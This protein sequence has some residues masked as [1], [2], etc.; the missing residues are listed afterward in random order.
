MSIAPS[1][2]S[3]PDPFPPR[4]F[5]ERMLARIHAGDESAVQELVAAM[6]VFVR[7]EAHALLRGPCR[8]REQTEDVAQDVLMSLLLRFPAIRD[9]D[10][11]MATTRRMIS[12]QVY[13]VYTRN[14]RECR[15]VRRESSVPDLDT[16]AGVA[17]LGNELT[18]PPQA[19]A[20]SESIDFLRIVLDL[21]RPKDRQVFDAFMAGQSVAEMAA[22][23][24]EKPDAVRMRLKR[25]TQEMKRA[26]RRRAPGQDPP[27]LGPV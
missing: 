8:V 25:A 14:M 19:A 27:S 17:A 9:H 10:H 26:W 24:G 12:N 22:A 13:D 15:D 6:E 4:E 5:V 23:F 18:P 3:G 21:M 7:Q 16:E 11:L 2:P 20:R 1:G